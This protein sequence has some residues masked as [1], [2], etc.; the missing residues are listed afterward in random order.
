[1]DGQFSREN[2]RFRDQSHQAADFLK[3][4]SWVVM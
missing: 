4:P 2:G 1:M 3:L